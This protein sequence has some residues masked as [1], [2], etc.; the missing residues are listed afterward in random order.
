MPES[1]RNLIFTNHAYARALDRSISTFDIWEAVNHPHQTFA[2]HNEGSTKFIKTI[3][4]RKLHVVAS[5]LKDKNMWL[6]ISVWVRGE[7]D[8]VPFMWMI[9]SAPFR[10]GWWLLTFLW[11]KIAAKSSRI[12]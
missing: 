5:Y 2:N 9:L 8:Q 11:K 6:V 12:I 3:Q 10:L 4:Q 7:E 1:F